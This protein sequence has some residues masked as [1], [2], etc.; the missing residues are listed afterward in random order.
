MY[1]YNDFD[2]KM[3]ADRVQQFRRQTERYLAG[4]LSDDEFR[5]LRLQNGLYIQ[6]IAPMLRVAVPYGLLSSTQVRKL[7]Q[8]AR[9]YD[10]G[11]VHVSTR[12]NIQYNWPQLEQVP[13]ILA[14]LATVEMHAIQT[15]GACIR[16]VTSDQFAGVARD[17]IEDPRPWAEIIRQWSTFHPE[18]AYLPRKFKIAVNASEHDRAAVKVHDIGVEIVR[19]AGETGFRIYV[20]GGLG[21]TPI[22]GEVICEFLPAVHLLTY[23]EAIVRVYNLLGRRDNLYKA[24]IKILVKALGIA[25]FR[26]KVEAEWAHL[27]DGPNT[28]SPEYIDHVKSFFVAPAYEQLDD[29]AADRGL[30]AQAAEHKAFGNWLERNVRPHKQPGYAIVNLSLKRAGIPPGDATDAQLDGVAD[31]ADAYSFGDPHHPQ[32]EHRARRCAQGRPV[33]RVAGPPQTGFRHTE[34]RLPDGHHLL[35]GRRLLLPGQRQV[36]SSGGRHPA[37]LR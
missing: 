25:A 14:E 28:L 22:I 12:Q 17:E 3:I 23:L 35:S 20:G 24:R 10:R 36:D 13:D 4:E 7:A 30:Q 37:H 1:K 26:E 27:V 5:P 15:S 31:L 19:S 16:N 34:H 29:A 11:Y 8:I 2:H 21:R 6:R 33:R 32:P 18:F 9:D